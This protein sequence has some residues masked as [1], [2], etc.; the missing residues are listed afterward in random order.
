MRRWM[1]RLLGVGFLAAIVYWLWWL[2]KDQQQTSPIEWVPQP[3]PSPPMPVLRADS[4]AESTVGPGVGTP[5]TVS[6]VAW[7]APDGDHCP[8]S[9][10]VTAKLTSGIYHQPGGQMYDRTTPDRC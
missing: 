4:K 5:T 1:K 2:F 3:F 6:D 9:H 10:P 7:V 8:A